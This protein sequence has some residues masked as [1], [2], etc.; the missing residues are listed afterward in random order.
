MCGRRCR[1]S[2]SPAYTCQCSCNGHAHGI[3]RTLA[4][5]AA[6]NDLPAKERRRR[7]REVRRLAAKERA[8]GQLFLIDKSAGNV[9][10]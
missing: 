1:E 8:E 5:K 7:Q 4:Q 9:V 10:L 2:L 3:T 6:W